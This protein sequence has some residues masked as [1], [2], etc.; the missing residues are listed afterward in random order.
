[1]VSRNLLF[2]RFFFSTLGSTVVAAII[3]IWMAYMGYGIWAL[4]AQQLSSVTVGT[5]ILWATVKWRPKWCFSF[6]RLR[7]L[8]SYGWKLLASSL[9]ETV[10]QDARQLIIGKMYQPADLAF[11]NKGSQFPRLIVSNVNTSIDSVLFPVMSQAQEHKEA[12]K[13]MT[14]RAIRT[15]IY[16]MA[17]LLLGLAVVS[18][19]VIVLLL[20][21]TWLPCVP[22][23][24]IF[25]F[26]YMFYP[27]HTANLNAIK[28]LG[29]SGYF[30][31]LEILKKI[32]GV[33]V[34][35][36]TMW[37]G[38]LVMCASGI[39]TTFIS[40]AI[41]AWP[42]KKLLDYSLL[43][44]YKDI[45]P[46]LLLTM[47]MGLCVWIVGAVLP[48]PTVITLIIQVLAGA[49]I[50]VGLSIAFKIDIFYDLLNLVKSLIKRI[51]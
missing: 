38:P 15:S 31:K 43:E 6:A 3:G 33:S 47:L 37:H 11:Y 16:I 46:S 34:L 48:L 20:T 36:I 42:N 27:I 41:N 35:L 29:K 14:R 17:P 8:F 51:K 40:Q 2:K 30:L 24:V 45:L 13:A 28:A 26:T 7:G 23:L 39:V 32:L 4:V 22:Y 21:E 1:Y 25:C 44:Q 49:A 19:K 5:A 50:Y 12:V 10:Y 18:D 9:I